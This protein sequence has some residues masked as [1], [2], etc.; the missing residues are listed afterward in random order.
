MLG[1]GRVQRDGLP[2]RREPAASV[3]GRAEGAQGAGEHDQLPPG[4]DAEICH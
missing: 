3:H 4:A 1:F 2:G